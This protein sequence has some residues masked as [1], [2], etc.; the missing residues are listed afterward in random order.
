MEPAEATP[1][2]GRSSRISRSHPSF[3]ATREQREFSFLHPFV[4][5]RKENRTEE[6]E[7][8]ETEAK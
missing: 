3:P 2:L 1:F 8:R 4:T 7:R 5:V 6:R